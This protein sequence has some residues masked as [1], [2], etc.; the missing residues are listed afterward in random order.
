MATT[1]EKTAE[2]DGS[3][4]PTAVLYQGAFVYANP[5][6]LDALGVSTL[7]ELAYTNA[8]W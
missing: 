5:A 8:P 2:L 7:D 3:A 6:L 4:V 1:Q